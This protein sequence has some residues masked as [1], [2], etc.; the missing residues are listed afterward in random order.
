M[1]PNRNAPQSEVDGKALASQSGTDSDAIRHEE[2]T[3]SPPPKENSPPQNM[4]ASEDQ[5]RIKELEATLQEKEQLIA[6]LTE[7]LWQVAEELGHRHHNDQEFDSISKNF[8]S[9]S[10]E[11][12]RAK[13]QVTE[14]ELA[15]EEKEQ[16]I[17]ALT[18]RLEQVAE[19]LDRRHRTGADRGM[20]ISGGVPQEVIEEQQKIS[21]DLHAVLELWQGMETDASLSRIELQ[22]SEL[23]QIVEK[24]FEAGPVAAKPSTLVDYLSSPTIES[25]PEEAVSQVEELPSEQLQPEDQTASV[26]V[27]DESN[28]ENSP[29][30]D[31]E[32]ASG[33]EAMK[34]KLLAGQGVDVDT[35]L[36]K[37]TIVPSTPPE[38]P[39]ETLIESTTQSL[40]ANIADSSQRTLSSYKPPLPQ[41]PAEIQYEQASND[42]L[43][44]AIRERDQYISQLIKRV[45][46]AETAVIPVNWEQLNNAPAELLEKLQVL[47]H[48]LEHNLGLAEVEISIER[49]R[50]SRTE[51][52]LQNREEQIRKKEKQMGLNLEREEEK[53]DDDEMDDDRKKSWL[54]FLN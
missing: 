26:P 52:M 16:V 51:S 8:E 22:I 32:D 11:N 54:G 23:K 4:S 36:A 1:D 14:L 10:A 18:E 17:V 49:A 48:D 38:P 12:L 30:A 6:V 47:H 37:K 42:Q 31:S 2:R 39:Q 45:R 21:Q 13:E 33:W 9:I 5:K 25:S 34:A 50:L 24:G 35:D 46:E 29:T 43:I 40:S 15:L 20:T 53:I 27:E 44:Q 3:P 7:R 41:A 19:Q 28:T